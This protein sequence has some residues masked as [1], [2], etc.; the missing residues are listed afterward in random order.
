MIF[1]LKQTNTQAEKL[2]PHRAGRGV[3]SWQLRTPL[4]GASSAKCVFP[5][6]LLREIA[7]GAP[8]SPSGL[9]GPLWRG[10][11]DL[12][13]LSTHC[14]TRPAVQNIVVC[15]QEFGLSENDPLR[16][17]Y[18]SDFDKILGMA[19]PAMAVA[20]FPTE[21]Q[22]MLQQGQLPEP[23]FSFY[24]SSQ[25]TQQYGR[26]LIL[27]GMDP[28]LYSGQITWTPMTQEVYWQIG[29]EEFAMGNQVAV[30]CSQGCQAIVDTR[31]FLL[32]VPQ[33]YMNAFLQATGAQQVQ[34]GDFLV[35]YSYIQD[36]PTVT[37]VLTGAQF[38]LPPSAY[39]LTNNGYYW[40]GIEATYLPSPSGQ[41]LWILGNV[42]LK[43]YYSVYDMANNT[44]GFVYS[45]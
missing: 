20:C 43:E 35:N 45:A 27:G 21:M 42:F 7:S 3:S 33:Q 1:P 23:G 18:Y 31:T 13:V 17:F 37:F 12:G 2:P 29:I 40:F 26:E 34:N 5:A 36:M 25:P 8:S 24:F 39:V 32:A 22:G 41:P 38:P 44:I 6:F 15:N 11:F 4:K 30:W 28:Q 14:W 10:L 16:P 9:P 19:Y